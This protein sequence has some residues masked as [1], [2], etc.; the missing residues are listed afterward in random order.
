MFQALYQYLILLLKHFNFGWEKNSSVHLGHLLKVQAVFCSCL[1]IVN[2]S[3]SCKLKLH[4]L[5]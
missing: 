5:T 2:S 4:Q 1:L 3:V